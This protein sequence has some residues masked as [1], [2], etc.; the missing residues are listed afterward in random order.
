MQSLATKLIKAI[1]QFSSSYN[2]RMHKDSLHLSTILFGFILTFTSSFGQTFFISL[3]SWPIRE[4]LSLTNFEF[5]A[6]Y[7]AATLLSAFALSMT[8]PMIDSLRLSTVT[9]ITLLGLFSGVVAFSFAEIHITILFVAL[10]CL[11]QF[12]QG[13]LTL[14]SSATISR[15]FQGARGRAISISTLGHPIGEAILPSIAVILLAHYG[16]QQTW[17]IIACSLAILSL[18]IILIS[19]RISSNREHTEQS[20]AAFTAPQTN[21]NWTRK[22]VLADSNFWLLLPMLNTVPFIITALFFHQ[23][24]I[25][26]DKQWSVELFAA[27]FS[28]YAL[29][30]VTGSLLSGALID[31]WN[32]R[33]VIRFTLIPLVLA[34]LVLSISNASYALW[35]FMGLAGLSAGAMFPASIASLSE[36]YGVR[37]IAS[38]KSSVVTVLVLSTAI[39]PPL[40]GWMLDQQVSVNTVARYLCAGAMV[41]VALGN[42]SI[43]R[44]NKRLKRRVSAD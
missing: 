13:L 6:L 25:A 39:S 11:R 34:C 42:A 23:T 16:L 40:I 35:V 30:Q 36:T 19:K 21:N 43:T 31:R 20:S 10:F 2:L 26:Q 37:H 28:F 18:L 22:E 12:G 44:I 4:S 29:A 9:G 33:I 41:T 3:F 1:K 27:S 17:L 14:I 38:I 5:S 15:G 7:S 32:A 24:S 8:G